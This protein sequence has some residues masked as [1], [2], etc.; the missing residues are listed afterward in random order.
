MADGRRGVR[1]G[2]GPSESLGHRFGDPLAERVDTRV[3]QGAVP[4]SASPAEPVART[5]VC[6][7]PEPPGVHTKFAGDR[8]VITPASSR[9]RR[10]G[11]KSSSARRW[12]CFDLMSS[13]R[14]NPG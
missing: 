10:P 13:T 9:S 3:S 11:A 5:F 1:R 8:P 12:R 6:T 7:V 14:A 4:A 2:S